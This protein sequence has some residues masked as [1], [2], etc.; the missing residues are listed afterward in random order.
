MEDYRM[1]EAENLTATIFAVKPYNGGSNILWHVWPQSNG[2]LRVHNAANKPMRIEY[3]TFTT[4]AQ[5]M[6][7]Q[8]EFLGV[9]NGGLPMP[10]LVEPGD[11]TT[12]PE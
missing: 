1:T 8:G 5:L 10:D 9:I 11:D 12:I 4:L 6:A 7:T 2:L 3:M